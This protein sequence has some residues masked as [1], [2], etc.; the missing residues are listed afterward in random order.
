MASNEHAYLS[1]PNLHNPKGLSLANNDT[2]CSKNNSGQLEWVSKS[3]IKTDTIINTGYCTLATN[4][5]FPSSVNNNN[6]APF[7]MNQ[8]Y[9]SPTISSVTLV[10]QNL[11]FRIFAPCASQDAV[12]NRC[13]IQ[14]TNDADVDTTFSVALVKY[15]PINSA[16]TVYPTVL[17]EKVVQGMDSNDK[18]LTTDLI[19]P[20]DFTNTNIS[21]GDHI[22]IMAKGIVDGELTSVGSASTVTVITELGYST[23]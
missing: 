17:F 21:K 10:N 22:F 4:Y 3:Y 18:V 20:S 5:K 13:R 9:G 15:T 16:T 2:L 7:D 19:V 1:E 8:D 23:N 12:I 14:V 11:F 6:K